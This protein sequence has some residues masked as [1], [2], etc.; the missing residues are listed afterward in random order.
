MSPEK[1]KIKTATVITAKMPT[2]LMNELPRRQ[3]VDEYH[4]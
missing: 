2:V 3:V 4:L 1:S